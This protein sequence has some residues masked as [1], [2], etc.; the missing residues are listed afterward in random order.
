MF[1]YIKYFFPVSLVY[2]LI[3][4]ILKGENYPTYFAL[5]FSIFFMI[6]DYLLI[7]DKK[8]QSYSFPKFLDLSI[9]IALPSLFLLIFLSVSV[10]STHNPQWYINMI[11]NI[12]GDDF[13][14]LKNSFNYLD[15]FSIIFMT[16]IIGGSMGITGGHEMAHRKKN[17]FDTFVG[18]WLLALSFDCNFAIEHVYGHHKNVCLPEDPASAKRGENIYSFVLKAIL[19]EHILGWKFELK[20]LSLK[21]LSFFNI[22]NRIIRGY[23]RSLSIA[24]L[25]LHFFGYLGLLTF[26]LIAFLSKVALESINYIEHYG[27]VR[28]R[29]K[30]VR[31]RHSWNSN[32]FLSSIYLYNVTRHSDHHKNSSLKFWELSPYNEKAPLLPYGYLTMLYLVLFLPLLYKK[33]MRKELDSWDKNYAN[34]FEKQLIKNY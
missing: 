12:T 3:F 25:F 30:P 23:S 22:Q 34:E 9:Y 15:K 24:A 32:H 29:G 5:L 27:L 7:R 13:I 16:V 21:K 19:K 10:F 11:K 14:N 33:I 4:S 18:N 8:V 20:R 2:L 28:E 6:G 31:M 17:R 1:K 26:L